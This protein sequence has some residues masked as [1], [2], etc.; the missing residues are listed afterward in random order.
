MA[1]PI[2]PLLAPLLKGHIDDAD[3]SSKIAR[4][5]EVARRAARCALLLSALLALQCVATD[6][7]TCVGASLALPLR[8]DYAVQAEDV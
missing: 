1:S 2:E 7:T 3:L 8:G 4:L 5:F 6:L